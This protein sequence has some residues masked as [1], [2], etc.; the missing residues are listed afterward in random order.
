MLVKTGQVRDRLA[1]VLG[2]ARQLQ[3]VRAVEAVA[4]ADLALLLGVRLYFDGVS[5]RPEDAI[6]RRRKLTPLTTAL[7]ASLACLEPLGAATMKRRISN[8][9]FSELAKSATA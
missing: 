6:G 7:A 9:S 2:S 8:R 1:G 3:G 4:K 5:Y